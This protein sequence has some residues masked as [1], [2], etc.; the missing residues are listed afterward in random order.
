M[1]ELKVKLFLTY[2][3]PERKEMMC[4]GDYLKEVGYAL[5]KVGIKFEIV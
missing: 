3:I 4:Y 1:K 2:Q 5:K